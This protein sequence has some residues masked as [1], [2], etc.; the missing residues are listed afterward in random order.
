MPLMLFGLFDYSETVDADPSQSV[1][2]AFFFFFTFLIPVYGH[3]TGNT[4][5][6]LKNYSRFLMLLQLTHGG[7]FFARHRQNITP[8]I[9]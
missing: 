3:N 1:S 6:L 7:M 8:G 9:R 2:Q 5:T 4:S